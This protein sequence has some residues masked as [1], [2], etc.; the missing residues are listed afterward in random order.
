MPEAIHK[1]DERRKNKVKPPDTAATPQFSTTDNPPAR[2]PIFPQ[3]L[4]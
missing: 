1:P 2:W 3:M 4:E